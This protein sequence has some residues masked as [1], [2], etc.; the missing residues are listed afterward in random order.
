MVE[1]EALQEIL[2]GTICPLTCTCGAKFE[3]AAGL[4]KALGEEPLCPVCEKR[5]LTAGGYSSESG[6]I[7]LGQPDPTRKKGRYVGPYRLRRLLGAGGMGSVHLAVGPDGEEVALKLLGGSLD[8]PSRMERFQREGSILSELNHPHVVAVI[9]LGVD[10]PT[11]RPWIALE[12]VHGP[13]LETVMETQGALAP[14]LV[15]GVVEQC[16]LAL[17]YLHKM[18]VLHRDL[19]AANVLLTP[20]GDVKLSDFGL[21]LDLFDSIRITLSGKVVG[22]PVAID[23]AVLEGAPWE[24]SADLYALGVLAFRLLTDLEPFPGQTPHQIFEAQLTV[25]PQ[26]VDTLVSGVPKELADL[27]ERLLL[28]VPS[29]RPTLEQVHEAIAPLLPHA[30]TMVRLVSAEFEPAEMY[31]STGDGGLAP[32]ERFHHYKIEAEIGRGGMG[33]VH[34]ARHL[35]LKRTVALKVLLAGTLA[36]ASDRRR[37]LREAQAAGALNHPNIVPILDAG[38]HEGT[39]FISMAYV[40]GTSLVKVLRQRRPREELLRLFLQI[41][42]G[43]QHAHT[44]GVIHRDLKP[45]NVIVDERG[46]PRILDFGIA[47]RLGEEQNLD[48]SG[49]E[50]GGALTTEGDILGTL[51]YMPPEQAAGQ[52]DDVDVRSDVYALGTILYE[53]VSGETPFHGTVPELL[54]HIHF[55]EPKA[56]SRLAP[57][58][59]WELDAICLKALEKEPDRRYQSTL[60]FRQDVMRFLEGVPIKA[61]RATLG[62][63]LRKWALRNKRR[64]A[65]ILVG[66]VVI[67]SLSGGWGGLWLQTERRYEASV[68]SQAESGINLYRSGDFRGA[69]ERFLAASALMRPG[70]VRVVEGDLAGAAP[71]ETGQPPEG[72]QYFTSD[73]LQRWARLAET[74]A[75]QAEVGRF[76]AEAQRHFTAGDLDAA[77]QDLTVAAGLAPDEPRVGRLLKLVASAHLQKGQQAALASKNGTLRQRRATLEV[78]RRSL[79][80]A[81][82]LAPNDPQAV[83]GLVAVAEELGKLAEAEQANAL[84]ARNREAWATKVEEGRIA[85]LEGDLEAA[86]RAFVQALAFDGRSPEAREGLVGVE[87]QMGKERQRVE[88]QAAAARDAEKERARLARVTALLESAQAAL[89]G[90]RLEEAR[91]AFTQALGFDGSNAA[92]REGLLELYRRE[93]EAA[94]R[95]GKRALRATIQGHLRQ[96]LAGR[97][98]GREAYREGGNPEAIREHYFDGLEA[99]RRTLLIDPNHRAALAIRREVTGELGSILIEQG[100]PELAGFVRRLG[101]LKADDRTPPPRDPHLVVIEAS[102]VNLR[103]AF[104]SAVL[105][106]PTRAF[107]DLRG[108]IQRT[109]GDRYRVSLEIRSRIDSSGRT[110]IVY[111][112]GVWILLEDLRRKTRQRLGPVRFEGGPYVRIVQVDSRGRRVVRPFDQSRGLDARPAIRKVTGLVLNAIK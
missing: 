74:R 95:E 96:A 54:H 92:A 84:R 23:P 1:E 110:P 107:R 35:K 104:G 51:R 93:Q 18:G 47:K 66:A 46:V 32:G 79:E 87:R 8:D 21:A 52:N 45:D 64:T 10:E 55:S 86:R 53:L 43:V 19:T 6:V 50:G 24:P 102:A 17:G 103:R 82:R 91:V 73:R 30:Q 89:K 9:D 72:P 12:A 38:E 33:V 101:G 56:P 7:P 108:Q 71:T 90:K 98:A 68:L 94:R 42:D 41:C 106:Q 83:E 25:V 60:E 26:R 29:E 77:A 61:R 109:S 4:I 65:A 81:Q 80:R 112:E 111:A 20:H 34:R 76:L 39:T 70:D 15:V 13:D 99:V 85:L 57:D 36:K 67:L 44:R 88:R 37:F 69:K 58:V 3:L 11:G 49:E 105:F 48:E 75:G 78:A 22:T 62:Y 59:P 16:G 27:V 63:A 14:D 31:S 40:R 100:L 28:K 97:N 5:P 2:T